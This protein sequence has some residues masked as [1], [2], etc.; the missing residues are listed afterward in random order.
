MGWRVDL[1]LLCGRPQAG[2][3]HVVP[4]RKGL[5]VSSCGFSSLIKLSSTLSYE[6]NPNFKTAVPIKSD[7]PKSVQRTDL[8]SVNVCLNSLQLLA[9]I[10]EASSK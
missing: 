6:F 5:A 8:F 1:E 10:E 3:G 9:G 2:R 7:L 4:E